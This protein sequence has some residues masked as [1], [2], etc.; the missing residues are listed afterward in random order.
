MRKQEDIWEFG[1]FVGGGNSAGGSGHCGEGC[2]DRIGPGCVRFDLEAIWSSWAKPVHAAYKER[3]INAIEQA[4][5]VLEVLR[6][7][8]ELAGKEPS[9][10]PGIRHTS[11]NVVDH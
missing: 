4:R 9:Q 8:P 5:Y 7:F 3:G 11:L 1:Y 6:I 10:I 2:G